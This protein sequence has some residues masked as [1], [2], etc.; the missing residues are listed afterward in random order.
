[1]TSKECHSCLTK[2]ILSSCG[3]TQE[4]TE[5]QE[6]SCLFHGLTCPSMRFEHM[7]SSISSKSSRLSLVLH[8]LQLPLE[9]SGGGLQLF[10]VFGRLLLV[11]CFG[12]GGQ[13][14]PHYCLLCLTVPFELIHGLW[15]LG[16]AWGTRRQ[17]LSCSSFP[18]RG[19]AGSLRRLAYAS[20][21][22]CGC[23]VG[24]L[25]LMATCPIPIRACAAVPCLL[26]RVLHRRLVIL[27][28][29]WLARLG[30]WLSV[31]RLRLLQI[32]GS[33]LQVTA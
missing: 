21:R 32:A 31:C 25:A 23:C 20:C 28:A 33:Q 22:I 24:R 14:P 30:F 1:M 12:A 29:S 17:A 6:T 5:R 15:F 2:S 8:Q 13:Q 10:Q 7:H 16:F 11:I 19:C 18:S 3:H 9:K 4:P 26:R 27:S